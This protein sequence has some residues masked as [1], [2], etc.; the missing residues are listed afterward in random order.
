MRTAAEDRKEAEAYVLQAGAPVSVGRRARLLEMAQSCL[1]LADQA[2][3]LASE[4]R[5]NGHDSD[6]LRLTGL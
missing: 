4:G 5:M 2:E 3:L 1:R 6:P